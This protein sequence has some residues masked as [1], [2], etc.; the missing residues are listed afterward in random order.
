MHQPANTE[1]DG[2]GDNKRFDIVKEYDRA[3]D[4]RYVLVQQVDIDKSNC[5]L[6]DDDDGIADNRTGM[7]PFQNPINRYRREH[8]YN[9]PYN[10]TPPYLARSMH[11]NGNN[12]RYAGDKH[13]HQ[14]QSAETD[15]IFRTLPN[16]SFNTYGASINIGIVTMPT[17][18]RFIL[19]V[20]TIS[21]FIRWKLPAA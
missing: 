12:V 7:M 14:E 9:V 2:S 10:G 4:L 6:A 8:I 21:W 17:K 5:C 11:A 16:Q 1:N 20:E 3:F 18:N 13:D 19:M 15:A